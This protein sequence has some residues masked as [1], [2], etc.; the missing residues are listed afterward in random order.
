M[1]TFSQALKKFI[2]PGELLPE[3]GHHVDKR[4]VTMG[5]ERLLG[6]IELQGIP[7]ETTPNRHLIQAYNSLTRIFTEI[8]KINA[9][10]VAEWLHISKRKVSLDFDYKFEN[11]FISDFSAKYLSQFKGG[12]F[13]RTTYHISFV[14]KYDDDLDHG[15]ESLNQLLDFALT[16]LKRY[17]AI[18]LSAEITPE[19]VTCSQVGKFLAR[20]LNGTD[21]LVPLSFES[22]TNKVQTAELNFGFDL[23]EIRPKEGGKKYA[24][25]FDLREYP[26]DP[27][28]AMWNSLLTEP[29]EFVLTQSFLNFTASKSL[30]LASKKINEI[31]SGTHY[32][33]DYVAELKAAMGAISSGKLAFGEF[34]GALVVFGDTP[35]EAVDNGNSLSTT[36]LATSGARFIR[37]TA[38][39]IYT[40]YSQMPASPFKPL[41]EPKTTRNLA[42]GFSLNNYPTGKQYGNPIGDG[43]AIMP[44]K[45]ISD[46]VFFFNMHYSNPGQDVR[47]QK[48]PGHTLCLGATGSGK[49]TLEGTVVGFLDR[50][51]PK[52]FAIDFNRSMQLFLETYGV[53][54]FDIVD[55]HDTGLQAFQLPDSPGLRSFLY[56]LVGSCGRDTDG[57]L[58]SSDEAKI[59][60]AVDVILDMNKED[61]RFSYLSTLIPP[62]GGDSLGDRL[63]KWQYSCNGK[64]AWALD[65]P[66]NM[67]DPS[68]MNRIG[69]NTTSIL[70]KGH[71]A[72]EQVLA[73]LFHMKDMMQT[74]GEL[75]LTLVEEFWVP[76]NYPITQEQ[77][78]GTLKA[79]RIKGEFMFLV[80]QSPE[81][82]INCAIFAD[83]I[84]MTPTKIFLPNP[85]ATFEQYEKCGL[86]EKEFA[87]L[88]E[89]DKTSRTFLI[90]QSHQSTFAKLDLSG[91]DDFLP[92]ISGTWE[93]IALSHQVKK[94]HGSDPKDWVPVFR[95]R[96]SSNDQKGSI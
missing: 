25:Y 41:A 59:K 79:G 50:F 43:S 21:E 65:S 66:T 51:K 90:K 61:R 69:F 53:V 40:Y 23:C 19:G 4:I 15:I 86:N 62:E 8:N 44:L 24:T 47:G 75:F 31:E 76:A 34:H 78:K 6:V 87:D 36:L 10:R 73:V 22:I 63:A 5:K 14:Y 91:Y 18:A 13:F 9:P 72:A 80:S 96:L 20:V 37:S 29:Y 55:G 33:E 88:Y 60:E 74:E 57:K 32:P 81:D 52:I 17:D 84:Q 67:F 28:R 7:F 83:I 11:Q 54:Y 48:Y 85:E 56:S 93:T 58:T 92:I 2:A 1:T 94:E 89:L 82:A 77:I 42:S 45:T 26:D 64:Y 68:T 30:A 49:T 39:G 38:S 95:Q 3:Y 70:K 46:S 35:K 16:S 27:K 12:K 71:P